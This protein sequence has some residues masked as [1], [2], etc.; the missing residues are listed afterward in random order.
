MKSRLPKYYEIK[1]KVI[2]NINKIRN[3]QRL[4][5]DNY[6]YSDGGNYISIGFYN[7]DGSINSDSTALYRHLKIDLIDGNYYVED[8]LLMK[9]AIINHY[10]Y[11]INERY[12]YFLYITRFKIN[13]SADETWI[14][15]WGFQICDYSLDDEQRKEVV[16]AMNEQNVHKRDQI[17]SS[18]LIFNPISL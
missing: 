11:G 3:K 13:K 18:I 1:T 2:M 4:R 8:A 16:E 17:I 6:P 14:H 9:G 7:E 12:S 10:D 5:D 15:L